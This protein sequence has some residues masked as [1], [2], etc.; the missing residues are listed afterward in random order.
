M[1]FQPQP[2]LFNVMGFNATGDL[3][4]FTLYTNKKGKLVWFIKAPPTTPP[5]Y[6]QDIKRNYF[7]RAAAA[8]ARMPDELKK[9]W[10]QVTKR[11]SLRLTGYDLWVFW[12]TCSDDLALRT[13]QRQSEINL[14]HL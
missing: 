11:L 7:R 13:L 6:Y 1:A 3:G 10:E 4:G 8:W 2:K 9:R 5:T 14:F 12:Y